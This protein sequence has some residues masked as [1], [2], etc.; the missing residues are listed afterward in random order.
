MSG[1]SGQGRV[2]VGRRLPNGSVGALEWVGNVPKLEVGLEEETS[3]RKES[4]T[5]QRLPFRRM[6]KSRAGS[7]AMTL[8]EATKANFARVLNGLATTVAAGAA[9]VGAVLPSPLVAGQS[10]M[11]GGNNVSGVAVR[12]SSGVPKVLQAGVNYRVSAFGGTI[13]ILDLTVGGPYVMPLV[14][15]FTP[16]QHVKIGAFRDSSAEFFIHFEGQNT[17]DGTEFVA[18][19]YRVRLSP[20]KSLQL[21][22]DDFA[23]FEIDGTVLADLTRASDLVGGQFFSLVLPAATA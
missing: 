11:L 17:D 6:T 22:N 18:D 2:M 8:D 13:E 7:F 12:D 19:I 15:D 1:F 5:G 16:G 20:T 3:E 21:I 4:Y 23:D 10:V 9:V 14:A